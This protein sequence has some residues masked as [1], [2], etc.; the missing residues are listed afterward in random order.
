V[1]NLGDPLPTGVQAWLRTWAVDPRAAADVSWKMT[2]STPIQAGALPPEAFDSKAERARVTALLDEYDREGLIGPA[3]DEGFA[4]VARARR[5]RDPF[6]FFLQLPVHRA[7]ELWITPVPEWE[8]PMTAPSLGLPA[9]RERL[10]PLNR[11]TLVFAL[12]GLLLALALPRTRPIAALAVIAALART[13]AVAFVVPGG[14]QRYTFE[15]L[16]LLL[17]LAALALVG[18]AELLYR[19]LRPSRA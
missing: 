3:V 9:S 8:M 2:R 11:R 5:Q 19:R 16:P 12:V 14:T 7:Y 1:T 6:R 18:P 13:V 15:L 17:V 4:E 10:S